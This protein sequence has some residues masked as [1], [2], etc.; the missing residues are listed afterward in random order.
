MVTKK[1]AQHAWDAGGGQGL[2]G[3]PG[4]G[5]GIGLPFGGGQGLPHST[6]LPPSHQGHG[7]NLTEGPQSGNN[8]VDHA[9]E[10]M[11]F[12][13][14]LGGFTVEELMGQIKALMKIKSPESIQQAQ[15]L[16]DVLRDKMQRLKAARRAF[17]AHVMIKNAS[18]V[19][20]LKVDPFVKALFAEHDLSLD[21]L[22]DV[23][24]PT[25]ITHF[26]LHRLANEL[27]EE[28]NV[29][30]LT[31]QQ[32]TEEDIARQNQERV[33]YEFQKELDEAYQE[34]R[35]AVE[36]ARDI[37]DALDLLTLLN[38]NYRDLLERWEAIIETNEAYS[39]EAKRL[40]IDLVDP[41]GRL[42]DKVQFD[43]REAMPDADTATLHAKDFYDLYAALSLAGYLDRAP[44]VV[45]KKVSDTIESF[46][47][48]IIQISRLES[49]Q[50]IIS[51]L[52]ASLCHHYGDEA[53]VSK[54][55]DPIRKQYGSVDNLL[56]KVQE[57]NIP[58]DRLAQTLRIFTVPSYAG[59]PHAVI[60]EEIGKLQEMLPVIPQNA[61]KV[62]AQLDHIVDLEHNTE[63][64]LRQ[65]V[66]MGDAQ[67][68]DDFEAGGRFG[69]KEFL[70]HKTDQW[71]WDFLEK[72]SP[73]F[74]NIYK[75]LKRL[76]LAKLEKILTRFAQT[77]QP[78]KG[79]CPESGKT[80]YMSQS[81]LVQNDYKA[82][83]PEGKRKLKDQKSV[84]ITEYKKHKKASVRSFVKTAQHAPT[85]EDVT[86]IAQE[87]MVALKNEDWKTAREQYLAL[88]Q[89]TQTFFND[90]IRQGFSAEVASY[91]LEGQEVPTQYTDEQ[92]TLLEK[93]D[94]LQ[95]QF[96]GPED[97]TVVQTQPIYEKTAPENMV[98]M[99][100]EM[101]RNDNWK[102]AEDIFHALSPGSQ[103]VVL[104]ALADEKQE[105]GLKRALE[106]A[107]RGEWDKAEEEWRDLPDE[108]QQWFLE[109]SSSMK[110]PNEPIGKRDRQYSEEEVADALKQRGMEGGAIALTAK[111]RLGAQLTDTVKEDGKKHYALWRKGPKGKGMLFN[112]QFYI[113][114]KMRAIQLTHFNVS[115]ELRRLHD[116]ERLSTPEVE[117]MRKELPN[118]LEVLTQVGNQYGYSVQSPKMLEL[119]KE[120]STKGFTKQAQQVA[121]EIKFN[122]KEQKIIDAVKQ[123]ADHLDINTYLV[124]GAV[125]DRLLGKENADL[126]FMCEERAEELVAY[127]AKSYSTEMPVQYDRSKALMITLDGET[128]EFVNAERLFR[129]LKQD[130]SMEGEE[131]FTTSFDDAY[132]RDLTINTLMYDIRKEELLDPTGK[133]LDDL[134]N[135]QLN[136]VIDPYIKYKIHAPDMLRALRFAATHD[137][138][139]GEG[140]M[141]AMRAN[142]ERIRPRDKGGDI[143]NRRIRKELRKA[144]DDPGHWAKLRSLLTEAGLDMVLA[145]DIDDVQQD[146]IGGIDYHLEEKS[147]MTRIKGFCKRAAGD[148]SK[149]LD[150]M[151]EEQGINPQTGK[152]MTQLEQQRREAPKPG[153]M[154]RMKGVFKRPTGPVAPEVG[155]SRVGYL[156]QKLDAL[157]SNTPR[158]KHDQ[159]LKQF[160]AQ[161]PRLSKEDQVEMMLMLTNY[162]PVTQ[163]TRP[164]S[165]EIDWKD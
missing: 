118:P 93:I 147:A 35:V 100:L 89:E 162:R 122:D 38:I 157:L 80:R 48:K 137:F 161:Y 143:S 165:Q 2:F 77:A 13:K 7:G 106:Y 140:M 84:S 11:P 65:Y 149:T 159:A 25:E 68:P 81:D 29:D 39:V 66:D 91:V 111:E 104:D 131:E 153:L 24:L 125:R 4:E 98:N 103:Y 129:P 17:D 133:G 88:P 90:K 79:K 34:V 156:A 135:K 67:V 23:V 113:E 50:E 109:W 110:L 95:Q 49:H 27:S 164:T 37:D 163:Q 105:G 42:Y 83:C 130:E 9:L 62:A 36:D 144:I 63:L 160:I 47:R 45:V 54:F 94:K 15:F 33:E 150:K 51:A 117:A 30:E 75:Q 86:A 32:H 22:D 8:T 108:Y 46:A 74:A 64:F 146:L 123:A 152:K 115:S 59:E 18:I 40:P 72:A 26:S 116:P 31:G 92:K 3:H 126:D 5:L 141:D 58:A 102:A 148:L 78:I 112:V 76:H 99:F 52:S 82:D 1:L 21:K 44:S 19:R 53:L 142:V 70:Q 6:N 43:L 136:T 20:N 28:M 56:A 151:L 96:S 71:D 145:D 14:T 85:Q 61:A 121:G 154:E 128:V 97:K 120:Q 158:E 57:L 73:E 87:L 127:L 134:R 69:F 16:Q 114:P 124:G 119:M 101:A 155:K 107:K 41:G 10:T 132:R 139:L 55:V 60:A 12:N 138:T